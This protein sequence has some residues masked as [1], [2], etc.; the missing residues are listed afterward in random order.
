MIRVP[1]YREVREGASV[2]DHCEMAEHGCQESVWSKGSV[3]GLIKALQFSLFH[4]N[5]NLLCRWTFL[6]LSKNAH[7]Y[8]SPCPL[9]HTYT[10]STVY[11]YFFH[12][13]TLLVSTQY[14][15][16]PKR[17]SRA[18][19]YRW[20]KQFKI[21]LT[22]LCLLSQLILCNSWWDC[23]K[24]PKYLLTQPYICCLDHFQILQ[25]QKDFA[26]SIPPA[27][28]NEVGF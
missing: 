10:H 1:G 7:Y 27:N 23:H 9:M 21:T 19:N 20:L 11:L 8:L 15:W 2:P 16:Y 25:W 14:P 26:N 3:T 12:A 6:S 5:S 28:F 4:D 24:R 18:M 22:H 13:I 17:I